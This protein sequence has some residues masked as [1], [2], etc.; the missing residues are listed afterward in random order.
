[1]LVV[2][3]RADETSGTI[4]VDRHLMVYGMDGSVVRIPGGAA[5]RLTL[6]LLV[7]WHC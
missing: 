1:M 7:I 4:A 2:L 3:E 6:T 5:S